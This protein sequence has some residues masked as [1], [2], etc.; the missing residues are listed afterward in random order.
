MRAQVTFDVGIR[1]TQ[2][3][4]PREAVRHTILTEDDYIDLEDFIHKIMDYKLSYVKVD[5]FEFTVQEGAN[6]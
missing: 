6:T 5:N 2:A 3:F 1:G 4:D